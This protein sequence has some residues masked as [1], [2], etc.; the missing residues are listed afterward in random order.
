[1]KQGSSTKPT[2]AAGKLTMNF[3]STINVD[4]IIQDQEEEDEIEDEQQR[5]EECLDTTNVTDF[6]V[7]LKQFIKDIHPASKF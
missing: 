4:Q 2:V 5:E 3:R 6:N 7:Y 1:M